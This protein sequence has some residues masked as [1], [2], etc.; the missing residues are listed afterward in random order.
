MKDI[1]ITGQTPEGESPRRV[2]VIC[3]AGQLGAVAL[4]SLFAS[5]LSA[6]CVSE[7][8]DNSELDRLARDVMR[9]PGPSIL[10]VLATPARPHN[11][12][13]VFRDPIHD[14]LFN[15]AGAPPNLADFVVERPLTKRQRRR[16]KGKCA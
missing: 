5:G 6:V 8:L 9:V 15:P 2:A 7:L 13:Q 1:E 10:D 14:R 4:A 11:A 16:L 12:R 3:G